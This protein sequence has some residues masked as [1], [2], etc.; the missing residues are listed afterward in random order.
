MVDIEEKL[1]EHLARIAYGA[2]C[3][4][5]GWKSA[6]TGANL[7]PYDNNIE[8]VKIGW[9]AAVKVVFQFCEYSLRK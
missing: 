5:T 1:I 8:A 3:E 7:P 9:R 4:T 6:I 2:Y